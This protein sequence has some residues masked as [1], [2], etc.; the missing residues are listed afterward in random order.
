V[1]R[2]ASDGKVAFEGYG[3]AVLTNSP[4]ST[5]SEDGGDAG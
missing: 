3:L 4:S 5:D 2:D 1:V